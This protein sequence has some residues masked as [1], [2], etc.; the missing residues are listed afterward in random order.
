MPKPIEELTFTDDGM[1]Q[2]VMHNPEICAELVERLLHIK[3][4]QV[5]YPKL[6][7]KIA[8]YYTSKGIRLDVYLKDED[9][10]IDIEIQN[11]PQEAL[12]KRTPGLY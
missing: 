5:K 1:F 10:V 12:G 9:K 3:V 7:K 8:P 11:Y 4:K 2:A 6:E